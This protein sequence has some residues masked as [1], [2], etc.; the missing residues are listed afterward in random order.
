MSEVIQDQS[1]ATLPQYMV[2]AYAAMNQSIEDRHD[3]FSPHITRSLTAI[4]QTALHALKTTPAGEERNAV[5]LGA[6][7]CLDLPLP[8]ILNEFD[9]V[10]LVDM[11]ATAMDK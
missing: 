11:D 8:G 2:D 7:S 6:G 4:A 1:V 10:T 5:I 9:A 3:S